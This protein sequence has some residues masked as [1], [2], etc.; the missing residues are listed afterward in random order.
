[1]SSLLYTKD[2]IQFIKSMVAEGR[3]RKEIAYTLG[4]TYKGLTQWLQRHS[5][6]YGIGPTRDK[7]GWKTSKERKVVKEQV[8]SPAPIP[9]KQE[10]KEKT[11][12]DFKCR[13]MIKYL[14][15]RDYRIRNNELV[16]LQEVKVSLSDIIN[17]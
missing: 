2:E 13:D 7:R 5:E 14:Y 17:N 11:L 12:S 8:V 9:V 3:T 4:K 10:V 1:M 15:G 6:K 16:V